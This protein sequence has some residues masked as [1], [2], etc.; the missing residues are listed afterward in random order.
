MA[1][2]MTNVALENI[3]YADSVL[4]VVDDAVDDGRNITFY[5]PLRKIERFLRIMH[6]A[7]VEVE[8]V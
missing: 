5:V 1:K 2:Y 3:R 7:G 4:H 6:D 8:R